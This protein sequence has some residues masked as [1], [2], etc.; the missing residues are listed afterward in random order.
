MGRGDSLNHYAVGNATRWF[1]EYLGGI[2]P[3]KAGFEEIVIKPYFFKE[4]KNAYVSYKSVRGTIVSAWEYNE[5]DDTF[6][7]TVTIPEGIAARI[8]LPHGM[9]R[10]GGAEIGAAQSGTMTTIVSEIS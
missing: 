7:W 1:F 4:L 2:K 9:R 6:T 3:V 10:T 5:E 8:E